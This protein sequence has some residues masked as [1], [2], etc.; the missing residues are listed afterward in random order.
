MKKNENVADITKTL[1]T[2]DFINI[3]LHGGSDLYSMIRI[4]N[5]LVR[6]FIEKD[7]PKFKDVFLENSKTEDKVGQDLKG[8]SLRCLRQL[9]AA[10]FCVTE[11]SAFICLYGEVD[12]IGLIEPIDSFF[13]MFKV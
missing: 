9:D 11:T 7:L 10:V 6:S 4:R 2:E 5:A 12:F 3:I 8:P 13:E 1:N